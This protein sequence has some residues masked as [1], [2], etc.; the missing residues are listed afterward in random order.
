MVPVCHINRI[1]SVVSRHTYKQE[2]IQFSPVLNYKLRIMATTL[3]SLLVFSLLSTT[4]G[5]Q[6][7][8]RLELAPSLPLPIKCN[9]TSYYCEQIT[10]STPFSNEDIT[11]NVDFNPWDDPMSAYVTLSVPKLRFDW[12]AS[13]KDGEQIEVPGFPLDIRGLP[14]GKVDA[15]IRVAMTKD[16]DTLSFEV[17]LVGWTDLTKTPYTVTLIEGKIP[18]IEKPEIIICDIG[19][20]HN[21][22]KFKKLPAPY[23]ALIITSAVVFLVLVALTVSF[24]C[25]RKRVTT[26]G[27]V[28]VMPPSYDEATSTKTKVPMQ[29]LID[30]I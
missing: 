22:N 20:G 27:Q 23:K 5:W 15:S 9:A 21:Y 6:D 26:T 24:C 29:P 11:L 3:L 4:L 10:C 13:V 17:N 8:C 16:N 25:K 14:V 1:T 7:E 18:H 28:K 30:E 2:H 12:S 19:W